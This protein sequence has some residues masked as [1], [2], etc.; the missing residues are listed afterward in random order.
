MVRF[1]CEE[2]E[3]EKKIEARRNQ[4]GISVNIQKLV[5]TFRRP[6]KE[7]LLR[8]EFKEVTKQS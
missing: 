4:Q 5:R 3:P 2:F 8:K 7:A 6:E 1:D